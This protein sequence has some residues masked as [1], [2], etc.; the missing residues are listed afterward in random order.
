MPNRELG[1][2]AEHRPDSDGDRIYTGTHAM[3]F[4]TSGVSRKPNGNAVAVGNA[5]VD[6]NS[7]FENYPGTVGHS[8]VKECRIQLTGRFLLYAK[9]DVNAGSAENL[10]TTA[11]WCGIRDGRDYTCDTSP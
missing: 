6:R 5:A 11:C 7:K 10:R 2:V 9:R 3:H 8:S 1:I 4:G